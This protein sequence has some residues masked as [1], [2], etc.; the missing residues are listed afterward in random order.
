MESKVKL[1]NIETDTSFQIIFKKNFHFVMD[2]EI[3][4]NGV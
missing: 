4:K 1:K 3:T 2:V